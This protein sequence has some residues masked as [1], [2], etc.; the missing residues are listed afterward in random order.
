M[1]GGGHTQGLRRLAAIGLEAVASVGPL[2]LHREILFILHQRRLGNFRHPKTFNEKLNW[3]IIYDR[4][5]LLQFS[6]DKLYTKG[7]AAKQ[8]IRSPRV[9]WSGTDLAEL[10]KLELPARWVLKPNHGSGR[11]HF[12][13]GPVTD[14]PLLRA[15]T[16]GWLESSGPERHGE[17]AY[18]QA[19]HLLLLEEMLGDG[20]NTPA[21]YNFYVFDGKPLFIGAIG[22]Q[23]VNFTTWRHSRG[24]PWPP[25][26]TAIRY[27]TSAW[28]PLP[29]RENGVPLAPEEAE[30]AALS[31]MTEAARRLGRGFDFMRVDLNCADGEVYFGELTPYDNGCFRRLEPSS[32]DLELGS[33]WTLP[34][35]GR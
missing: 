28:E 5:E 17:W 31:S 25:A 3:R 7:L 22:P 9:L 30:P 29:V 26:G 21:L 10:T 27:Y 32:F 35:L 1:R 15:A 20:V 16:Q 24:A 18:K 14:L 23:P 33:H 12:G 6:C 19:R 4:R 13:Q 11:L 34:D 2:W 8:D